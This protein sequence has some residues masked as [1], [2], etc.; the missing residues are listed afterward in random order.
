[1]SIYFKFFFYNLSCDETAMGLYV[2]KFQVII[3]NKIILTKGCLFI[4]H[5]KGNCT[6]NKKN[7]LKLLYTKDPTAFGSLKKLTKASRLSSKK[8]NFL[9]S[10]SS[11]TKYGLF[12]KKYPHL[13]VIVTENKKKLVL[14]LAYVDKFAKKGRGV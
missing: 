14:D 11:H 6:I 5:K 2:T 7:K 4:L 12:R 1:M 13:K 10:Q 8:W 9:R 3:R